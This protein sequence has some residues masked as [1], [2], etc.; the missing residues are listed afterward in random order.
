MINYENLGKIL[1][2]EHLEKNSFEFSK[3]YSNGGNKFIDQM[4][5]VTHPQHPILQI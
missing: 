5:Q 3:V 4:T 1:L 2:N